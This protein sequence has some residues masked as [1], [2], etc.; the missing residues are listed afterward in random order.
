MHLT[1]RFVFACLLGTFVHQ[2]LLTPAQAGLIGFPAP[3]LQPFQFEVG[4]SGDSFKADLTGDGDARA[5][6]GRALVTLS[7]GLTSWSEVYAR[8]GTAEFNI[9][10]AVFKGGFAP[11]FG[12]GVRLR[13]WRLPYMDL[14]LIAQYLR[15][16][17]N[18]DD[19]AGANVDGTWEEFDVGFSLGTRQLGVFQLYTGVTYHQIKIALDEPD[20]DISL[21]QE[22]PV[23]VFAGVLIYPFTDFPKG[24]FTV[25]VELRLVGEIPQFTLGLHVRF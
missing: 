19:S 20:E 24:N 5:T 10:E 17:S 18:D 7:L 22:L 12:G 11:A 2:G 14:G 3:R 15:F 6:T 8:V 23:I 9:D 1:A 16:T 4:L 13:L 25:N 21:H